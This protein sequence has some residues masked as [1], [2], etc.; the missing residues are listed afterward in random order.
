MDYISNHA[1]FTWYIDTPLGQLDKNHPE[2]PLSPQFYYA[3]VYYKY[4]PKKGYSFVVVEIPLQH[5]PYINFQFPRT[6]TQIL[7]MMWEMAEALDCMLIKNYATR[8]SPEKLEKLLAK[9]SRKKK[10]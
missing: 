8:I 1:E 9:Y 2:Y 10:E 7:E 3:R 4:K 6:T 5:C